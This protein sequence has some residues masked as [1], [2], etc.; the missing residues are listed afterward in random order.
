MVLG[1]IAHFLLFLPVGNGSP[2]GFGMPVLAVGW[3]L[4][5]EM[6]FYALLQHLAAVWALALVGAGRMAGFASA[7]DHRGSHFQDSA[8]ALAVGPCQAGF[9]RSVCALATGYTKIY[10]QCKVKDAQ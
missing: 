5:D 7:T 2:P 6:Y 10:Y 9:A 4:N 1:H 8:G 3:T